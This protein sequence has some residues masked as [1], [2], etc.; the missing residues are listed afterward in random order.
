MRILVANRSE[1]AV[2]IIKAIQELGHEAIA[3]YSTADRDSM[4]V[5]MADHA[6]CVGPA[7]ASESYL[8]MLN[9][10]TSANCLDV[11]MIHP[12]Y[13]FLSE[14]SEFARLC[15]ELKL[16]FIGPTSEAIELMGNKINALEVMATAS[17]SQN[18]FI[19]VKNDREVL[20]AAEKIDFPLIIKYANGGG[21]KGMRICLKPEQLLENYH[22]VISE[23]KLMEANPRIF[24]EKYITNAKHIEVQVACDQHG[25][26][27]TFGTR[28]CS[29]QRNSQK[30]I[31]E[32]PALVAPKLITKMESIAL[33]I[34]K[35]INYEGVGTVEFMVNEGEVYFLEMNT[36]LQVE[37][38]VT[39]ESYEVDLVKL[40]IE[41]ASGAN[42]SEQQ[43]A[44]KPLHHSIECRINA[45]DPN[46]NFM[47]MPGVITNIKYPNGCR[48]DFGVESGSQISPFYD[49][50]IGK[51]IVS[52]NSREQA[53]AKMIEALN[54]LEIRGVVTNRDF[55]IKL[56]QTSEFTENVHTTEYIKN[57]LERLIKE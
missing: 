23:A 17:D 13:G 25:N 6:V 9:I 19:E 49:S 54:E 36:R 30:V 41:I 15:E 40:Q 37:H 51:I 33:N 28:D 53:I 27:Y 16:K 2:R 38:T 52:A 42:I 12:G 1:I 21:G 35:Q 48:L 18:Q 50:M 5:K 11:D 55:N 46:L 29:M 34:C 14:N 47:P 7:N 8:H 44:T 39:E 3:I 43:F 32:A 10:L 4:H 31:E 20:C 22:L 26:C 56:L 45:E 57:H 24:I